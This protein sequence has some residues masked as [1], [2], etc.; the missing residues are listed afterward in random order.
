MLEGHHARSLHARQA[1]CGFFD[2][3]VWDNNVGLLLSTEVSAMMFCPFHSL[4]V[5][6]IRCSALEPSNFV[7]SLQQ[8]CAAL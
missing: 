1:L 3:I 6:D 4:P 7:P 8:L 5:V 2:G